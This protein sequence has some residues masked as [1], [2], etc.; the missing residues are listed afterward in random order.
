MPFSSEDKLQW[1]VQKLQA[2]TRNLSRPFLSQPTFW[3]GLGTLAL[4]IGTNVVQ[5]SKAEL[6][7]KQAE[8]DT[9]NLKL[10]M[11]QLT[12][13]KT[14]MEGTLSEQRAQLAQVSE[15]LKRQQE[16]LGQLKTEAAAA[17]ASREVLQSVTELQRSTDDLGTIVAKSSR[18]LDSVERPS[19][20]RD[21]EKAGQL[22]ARA[23]EALLA[24]DFAGAQKLFQESEEAANGFRFSYE[25]AR[26]LKTRRAELDT[27]AGQRTVLQAALAK[28][29][30][31]FAPAEIRSRL[32]KQAE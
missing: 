17:G 6:A 27:P 4:S 14:E 10:D 16:A 5:F 32:Q 29:F 9:A 25:W 30:A 7:K 2:E 11:R 21:A 22:E 23:Y 19:T 18:R 8:I 13:Q 1:E 3:V 24:R 28:G 12:I 15:E 20:A 31:R 26:L